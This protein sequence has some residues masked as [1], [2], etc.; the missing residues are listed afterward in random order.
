MHPRSAKAAESL[1]RDA[2]DIRANVIDYLKRK[3]TL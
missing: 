3:S 2:G 1:K